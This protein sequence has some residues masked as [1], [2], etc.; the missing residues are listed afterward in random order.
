[1]CVCVFSRIVFFFGAA[2]VV[3]GVV[4]ARAFSALVVCLCLSRV[5]VKPETRVTFP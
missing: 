2:R 5:P 1:M 3:V 4:D